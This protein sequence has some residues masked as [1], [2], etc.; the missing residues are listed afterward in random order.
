VVVD[1]VIGLLA[2]QEFAEEKHTEPEEEQVAS[3]A[4][5]VG[6]VGSEEP[7]VEEPSTSSAWV[8]GLER[9]R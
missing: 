7:V 3:V 4:E 1:A 8:N 2:N 6:V 5:V 9:E